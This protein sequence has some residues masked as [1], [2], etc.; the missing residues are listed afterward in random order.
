MT[1]YWSVSLALADILVSEPASRPA[2]VAARHAP[3]TS[4]LWI[5]AWQF[6]EWLRLAARHRDRGRTDHGADV[7]GGAED[8]AGA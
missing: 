7:P 6:L 4:V 8:G 2:G 5:G 3:V 1:S